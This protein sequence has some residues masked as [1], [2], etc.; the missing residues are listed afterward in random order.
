MLRRDGEDDM[1]EAFVVYFVAWIDLLNARCEM[2]FSATS[3]DESGCRVGEDAAE[4][5]CR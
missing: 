5:C 4:I 2:N 1:V 3:L